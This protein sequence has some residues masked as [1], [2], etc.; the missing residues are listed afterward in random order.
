MKGIGRSISVLL[1]TEHLIARRRLTVARNQII[2]LIGAAIAT[3]LGVIML[4]LAAFLGLREVMPPYWAALIVACANLTVAVIVAIIAL[5]MSA[6]REA[7]QATELRERS[8]EHIEAELD[9]TMTEIR[10]VTDSLHKMANDPLGTVAPS[11]LGP[12]IAKLMQ[13]SDADETPDQGDKTES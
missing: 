8:I 5:N 2:L 1:R 3:G 9:S 6:E 11:I 4:N 10:E 7:D 13:R 12:L